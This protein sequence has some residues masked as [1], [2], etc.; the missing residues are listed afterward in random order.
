MNTAPRRLLP[1][2]LVLAACTATHAQDRQR[3]DRDDRGP[4]LQLVCYGGAEKTTAEVHSG[5]EWDAQQHKYVPKQSVETGKADFQATITVSIHG[6][7]GDIQLPKSLIP[8]LHGDNRDGWW[9]ID[10]LLVGHDEIRGKFRLNALN[11]PRLSINRRTGAM[12]V[13]GMIKFNGRCDA[14][15]GHRRF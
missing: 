2:I 10:D 14:D 3:D 4:D 9:R 7:R 15:D 8:P 1:L 11:Q 6:D 12:T 13:D 5:Y